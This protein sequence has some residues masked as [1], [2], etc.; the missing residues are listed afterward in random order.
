MGIVHAKFVPAE[1]DGMKKIKK[2]RYAGPCPQFILTDCE[3]SEA[4]QLKFLSQICLPFDHRD[5]IGSPRL[6]RWLENTGS[7]TGSEV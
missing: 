3:S 4:T 1:L 7:G 5:A 6:E 2:L